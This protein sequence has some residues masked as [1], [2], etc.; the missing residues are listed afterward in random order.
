[1]IPLVSRSHDIDTTLPV[2]DAGCVSIH[3]TPSAGTSDRSPT[4]STI[5]TSG[6]G[7]KS[8]RGR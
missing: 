5:G 3:T 2:N 6:F 4:R 7:W 1:M 8:W